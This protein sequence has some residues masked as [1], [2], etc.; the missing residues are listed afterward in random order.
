MK[1][2]EPK[3]LLVAYPDMFHNNMPVDALMAIHGER[4]VQL[5]KDG[6]VHPFDYFGEPGIPAARV[7]TVIGVAIYTCS[8]DIVIKL[9]P[10]VGQ[11]GDRPCTWYGGR[12][13]FSQTCLQ[14]AFLKWSVRELG[15]LFDHGV[16]PFSQRYRRTTV[17]GF[18]LSNEFLQAAHDNRYECVVA[19]IDHFRPPIDQVSV[20]IRLMNLGRDME[21]VHLDR[22]LAKCQAYIDATIA[23]DAACTALMWTCERGLAAEWRDLAW[24]FGERFALHTDL[25]GWGFDS[26]DDGRPNKLRKL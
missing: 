22:A 6:Y 9:L 14:I 1:G 23:K 8:K 12:G 19:M 15:L 18:R 16:D 4:L 21:D 26:D 10:F 25:S 11:L 2:E 5:V 24:I 17:N 20:A 13:S 7:W 3:D